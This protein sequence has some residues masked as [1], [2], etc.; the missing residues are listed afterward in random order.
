ML[1]IPTF[2]ELNLLPALPAISVATWAV[3]L[4]LIDLWIPKDR[5]QLTAILAAGNIA[6][7]FVA[8][9]LVYN[10]N[11]DV[12][13][14]MYRA[15]AFTG[16]MNIIILVTAFI[17]ILMSI[18]YIKRT[19]IERGE[20]YTLMLF[21]VAGMMFMVAANDLVA[22]F[23]ALELLSIPLYIL[24]A[25]R[26]P[27]LKS[28]EAGLKY[29]V[30]GAFSSA[31]FVFGA[32]MIYG[33]TGSSNL[34]EIFAAVNGVIASESTAVIYLLLGT[35]LLLVALGFKVAAV[36]FHMWTPDVYEGA[37]TSVTAFMSVGAK[38]GGFGAL[39]RLSVVG[40]G[41]IVLNETDAA[42]WQTAFALLA[43]LTVIV[44]NF[45]AIAQ[46]NIKRMLAYSSIAHAGYIFIA[47]AAAG[48]PG[49]ENTAVQAASIYMLSYLFTNLGAFA[50]AMA[51]EKS[52]GTGTEIDDF[53]GL[54]RTRPLLALMMT[55]F[56]LSLTG[57][58]LTAGFI[59]KAMVFAAAVQGGLFVLAVIGVLTSV[60]S[61]F[62]YTR[63]IVNMYLREPAAGSTAD[64]A[65][66]A[67]P[68]LNWAVYISFVGT[69]IFG[70]LP[71]L[72]TT[73]SDRIVLVA[74][75]TP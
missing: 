14:G 55:V 53:I 30:L 42:T 52:D 29:F 72:I 4:L 66:G 24:A 71:V 19:G 21:S 16:F 67:T 57:I 12:L 48:T 65:E 47:V 58:P 17:S 15:D 49:N 8:N 41:G 45:A 7:A 59:G 32:A 27:D 34:N 10:S 56:M 6:F 33:A 63:V 61:A 69:L 46:T 20:Y 26:A 13:F 31:F 23:V 5:K 75:I 1:T 11:T 64:L 60:V 73:L 36:P 35:G 68:A 43:G 38:A 74:N 2:E 51:V 25:F 3:I 18:D 40:L 44:G 37:P 70:I 9:L 62:Y 22:I 54:A 39:L 28:E 50:I